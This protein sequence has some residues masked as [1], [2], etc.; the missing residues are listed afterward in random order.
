MK[1]TDVLLGRKRSEAPEEQPPGDWREEVQALPIHIVSPGKFQPRREFDEKSL[2]ELAQSIKIHGLLHPIV[3]RRATIGYEVIV[4]ERRLRACKQLGW[5]SIPA[6]VREIGDREAAELALIE[7]LQ[8]TDLHVFEV[9]EGYERL[10]NEFGLTQEELGERLG[11]SQ[12]NIANKIRLL[13]LPAGVRQ[14]IS[15]EMLSERHS[16]ALLKLEEEQD[17]LEVLQVVLE[18]GLNV[19]ETEKLVNSQLAKKGGPEKEKK[20][21]GLRK[22]VLKDIRLFTNSVRQL[23]ETLRASGLQARVEERED[24]EVYEILV[25][26]EKPRR[27]E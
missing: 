14:I 25:V 22:L 11:I 8:R 6:I 7:N 19:K 24:E 27:G 16:R 10:L 17:Q 2:G 4:G 23:T 5:E 15:R 21:A 26:V 12:G 13:K 18:Q 1:L 3:V 20:E 9:A